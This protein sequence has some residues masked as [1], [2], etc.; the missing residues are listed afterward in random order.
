MRRILV[1]GTADTKGEELSYL[2]AQVAEAGGIPIVVDVGIG[3]PKCKVDVARQEVAAHSDPA[4]LDRRDR[5]ASVAGMGE[6][7][8]KFL[9]AFRGFDAILGIGGGGGSSIVARGMRSLPIGL[10]SS[11]SPR[12]RPAM[13]LRS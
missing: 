7:F 10:P 12:S 1:V 8:E 5:G 3:E 2:R 4:I 13:S 6:A 9:A 11:S